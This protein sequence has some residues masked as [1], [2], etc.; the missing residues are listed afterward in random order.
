MSFLRRAKGFGYRLELFFL[1]TSDPVMNAARV[2]TRMRRGGHAVPLD[3]V[4]SR[5]PGSIRTALE[6]S[7]IVDGLR[8]YDN[9]EWGYSPLLLGWW[10]DQEPKYVAESIPRWAV[11]FFPSSV[12]S[13]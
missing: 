3:K 9:T 12:E 4:V 1:C 7:K 5:Y 8:V 10:E 11:P 13:T 2:R 6:A